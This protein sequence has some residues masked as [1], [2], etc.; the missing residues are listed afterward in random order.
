[1]S[2][3]LVRIGVDIDTETNRRVERWAE[4][5]GRSKRRHTEIV[6]RRIAEL[7]EQQ[8]AEL[9]RLG[10]IGPTAVQSLAH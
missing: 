2:N 4:A 7:V 9:A 6:M 3:R 8:P 1:M 10:L 5:E